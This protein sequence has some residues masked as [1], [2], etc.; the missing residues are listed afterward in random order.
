MQERIEQASIRVGNAQSGGCRQGSQF[1]KPRGQFQNRGQTSH[2]RPNFSAQKKRKFEDNRFQGPSQSQASNAGKWCYNCG[3]MGHMKGNCP[4]MKCFRCGRLGHS[5]RYCTDQGMGT[6][7]AG[8]GIVIAA[9]PIRSYDG[10]NAVV[11]GEPSH[12]FAIGEPSRV[13]AIDYPVT[14]DVGPAV[15]RGTILLHSSCTKCVV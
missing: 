12:V 11:P 5:D 3:Q 6:R 8:T 15:V 1:R 2:S 10:R 13:L 7:Q 9:Q 4:T 14:D